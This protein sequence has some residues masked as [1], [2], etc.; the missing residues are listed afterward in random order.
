MTNSQKLP[1]YFL[2][3]TSMANITNSD[4]DLSKVDSADLETLAKKIED[5]YQSDAT[6]K[7][8]LSYHWNKAQ[9]FLDGNQWIVY[10]GN[11]ASGGVWKTLQVSKANEYIPR[12][13]TNYIY[14]TYQTLKSYLI[15][16]RPRSTVTPNTLLNKDKQAAKLAALVIETN[17]ERL[18]EEKNYEYAAANG[19]AYGT[20]FKKDYWDT[21]S[22]QVAKV[23]RLSQ[24][25]IIEPNTSAVM[26]YE[27]KE[28]IDP[29]SGQP[30]FDEI[31]LG[32]LNTSVIEPHRLALDPLATDIHSA[33]WIMEYSIQTLDWLS[34]TYDKEGPG[35]T[36]RVSEVKPETAL[37]SS[38]QRYYELKTSSGVK[39]SGGLG[40]SGTGSSEMIDNGVVVKEY[41]ERPTRR[42]PKGRLVVVANGI[43]VYS[44]RSPYEGP[45]MGDWHPYSEFRW[46]IVPGRFWGKSPLDDATEIQKHI[47]SIDSAIILTRKTM[48][49]P[50]KLIPNDS[51]IIPGE[52]TGRPGQEVRYRSTGAKPETILS[53]GVAPQV[54]QERE[55]RLAD[56]KA[57]SGAIDIL[58]G[59]RP[60][61]VTAA[62]A[63]EMLFEVGTG[64]LRP[65]LDRWKQFIES[66]QKKQLKLVSQKYRESRP[67]FVR[68]MHM[69]NKDVDPETINAFIGSDLYDNCN[70]CVEAGS[71]IP[72]L[73][74]AHKAQL[75]QMAQIGTLNLDDPRNQMEFNKRLGIIGFDNTSSPD[76]RRAEWEND[77]LDSSDNP[78]EHPC[79]VLA[80]E[81][82][83]IHKELHLRRMKEPSFMRASQQVMAAFQAHL[84]EHEQYLQMNQQMQAEAAASG[85]PPQAPAP[86]Q[87]PPHPAGKG[88]SS[89]MS[90]RIQGADLPKVS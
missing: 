32:D 89:A 30:L 90:E 82:H 33:R 37:S 50:Q 4:L 69:K 22:L 35:Y 87:T 28:V 80:D 83:E 64:K 76:V 17:W 65:G 7:S 10:E 6:V 70:V 86:T 45:E 14:D 60:P 88:I 21:T 58:K 12:P 54:F 47:N 18:K 39:G 84:A 3:H 9:Q 44:D 13:V 67:D 48:A 53:A 24:Q 72:K 16:Q 36:G 15:Q 78:T 63:L 75:L 51:G 77:I 31:P 1:A 42:N 26:G 2:D 59:D 29:E 61:G 27:E 79:V 41:Y 57:I 5:Y 38:M 49:V 40:P 81:M 52:W 11:R 74:S 68:M 8:G 34:E 71:N 20:V 46:E 19:V 55:Q 66:S 73:E 56:M 43:V 85:V 23:P 25:P 62:S